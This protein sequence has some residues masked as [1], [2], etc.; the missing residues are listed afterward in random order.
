MLELGCGRIEY[1]E[2]NNESVTQNLHSSCLLPIF[3]TITLEDI[4]V[5]TLK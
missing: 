2:N 3:H 5:T 1:D 4:F